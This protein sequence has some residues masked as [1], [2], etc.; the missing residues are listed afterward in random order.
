MNNIFTKDNSNKEDT[1]R[2]LSL[3]S[4]IGAFEKALSRKNIPHEVVAYCEVNKYASTAYSAIHDVPEEKNLGDISKID[5]ATLPD[6]DLI[7]YG[8]PCFL[9]G[10]LV[11]TDQGYKKIEDVQVGNFVLTHKNRYKKVLSIMDKE[12]DQYFIIENSA[13][14]NIKVTKNHPFYTRKR[15]LNKNN[16]VVFEEP[17]WTETKDLT[18]NHYL[19][20]AINNENKK[21]NLDKYAFSE[22]EK[23]KL[24][25]Y[26][27]NQNFWWLIGYW[28]AHENS[29][30]GISI[31]SCNKS[32]S[33]A[34]LI[35]NKLHALNIAYTLTENDNSYD[36]L[37]KDKILNK[38]IYFL[39]SQS[40]R[41]YGD[42]ISLDVSLLRTLMTAYFLDNHYVSSSG[43]TIVKFENDKVVYSFGQ[44]IAKVFKESFR[45]TKIEESYYLSFFHEDNI[46]EDSF[47]SNGYLW[48]P[49]NDIRSKQENNIVYNL[50]VEGDNSYTVYNL[51]VH[52]CQDI[53]NAGKKRGIIKDKTRSGLLY[54][55]LDIIEEKKPKYAICEN[56]KNLVGKNFKKDFDNL[57][58]VLDDLGYNNYWKVVNSKDQG[59]P[60]N[61][62][63]V[64][65][66]S[67]RKDLEKEYTF[68]T[69]VLLD[70]N[71]ESLLEKEIDEKFYLSEQGVERLKH[72]NNKI[73]SNDTPIVSGC[74]HAGYYKMGGRDQQY[75]KIS[76]TYEFPENTELQVKLKDLLEDDVDDSYYVEKDRINNLLKELVDK[77]CI[78][79]REGTMKGYSEALEGDSININYPNSI[80]RRGRVGKEMSNTLVTATQICVVEKVK[81]DKKTRKLETI[82]EK[83]LLE[84]AEKNNTLPEF[85]NAYNKRT[86]DEVSPT[87]TT[88][89]GSPTSISGIVKCEGITQ[90]KSDVITYNIP[91]KVRVRVYDVD[92]TK[93][94]K[95][96]KTQKEKTK[97]SARELSRRLNIPQTLVE[98]WF[99]GEDSFA[100]PHP[101]IWES[102]KQE[103]KIETTEFDEAITTFEE[104]DGSYDKSNRIYDVEG[105]IPTLTTICKEH[106]IIDLETFR[107][108]KLTPLETWLLM[109]FDPE[110]FYRAKEA[111]IQK[112]YCKNKKYEEVNM[113]YNA[114]KEQLLLKYNNNFSQEYYNE[115]KKLI[116]KYYKDKDKSNCQLYKMAG[117]SIV[118]RVLEG[119]LSQLLK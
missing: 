12:T 104:K 3:F 106:T 59:V 21:F 69:E 70:C 81:D 105:S 5:F 95:L 75:V 73:M 93:L 32:L 18:N 42:F 49:I 103:L 40:E 91:T 25:N 112:Y 64:F 82:L 44:M 13:S 53:S 17:K 107:I 61:R 27:E 111:L 57:L 24:S 10:S 94:Q 4:G 36:F 35:A 74:I 43:E 6:C 26:I 118:V 29:L 11:L 92:K 47:Y 15:C 55:A 84:Y 31:I 62:E 46:V 1:L 99:R 86:F 100:I 88:T 56:V 66:V 72:H 51:I 115:R 109:S 97:L 52:N 48:I 90:K 117:N 113:K 116:E 30:N 58:E 87:I 101:E 9:G 80:I 39:K 77:N 28:I 37:I 22:I 79:V 33:F 19:G 2:V 16:K 60:Q 67:I 96:L 65:V 98:H 63:R 110:D 76:K 68:P 7:T 8:F 119:I 71:L 102:L 89:V 108:R 85:F 34:S 78:A 45:I 50:E 41:M 20:I 38:F 23:I 14:E 83:R 114:E 54:Y